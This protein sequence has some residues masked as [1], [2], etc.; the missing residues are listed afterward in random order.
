[1]KY[2]IDRAKKRKKKE[3]NEGRINRFRKYLLKKKEQR[4]R[5]RWLERP[6]NERIEFWYTLESNQISQPARSYLSSKGL[7][8]ASQKGERKYNTRKYSV[9]VRVFLAVWY[10]P[11]RRSRRGGG[12]KKKPP[13]LPTR[14]NKGALFIP[15]HVADYKIFSRF[16]ATSAPL[17]YGVTPPRLVKNIFN[18][19]RY[20]SSCLRLD[21]N[22]LLLISQTYTRVFFI[23]VE[24]WLE[25]KREKEEKV[26]KKRRRHQGR[27]FLAVVL[28]SFFT[29]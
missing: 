12:N 18:I 21:F 22:P 9:I 26:E 3:R 10:H 13:R 25:L 19:S 28:L 16:T 14:A 11:T 27:I 1:M 7:I 4:Q 29:R 17:I 23:F 20:E 8:V 6:V 24:S 5:S 15:H 2:R